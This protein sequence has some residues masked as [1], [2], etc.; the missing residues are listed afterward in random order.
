MWQARALTTTPLHHYSSPNNNVI[1]I[2]FLTHWTNKI[3]LGPSKTLTKLVHAKFS[4]CQ[5]GAHWDTTKYSITTS[6][7]HTEIKHIACAL[8]VGKVKCDLRSPGLMV[9]FNLDWLCCLSIL[10]FVFWV[11]SSLN[12]VHLQQRQL[13]LLL[14][15]WRLHLVRLQ[16]VLEYHKIIVRRRTR[17]V[18]EHLQSW[19]AAQTC[20]YFGGIRTEILRQKLQITF[21]WLT[22]SYK[23]WPV[24]LPVNNISKLKVFTCPTHNKNDCRVLWIG[25]L[26][27]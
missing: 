3:L 18:M 20:N 8:F 15:R 27:Y 4:I 25:K 22:F 19:I 12:F 5:G 24:N 14:F 6:V 11:F 21:S 9:I 23:P 16:L 7:S 26:M 17:I 13:L 1:R 2:W 10:R